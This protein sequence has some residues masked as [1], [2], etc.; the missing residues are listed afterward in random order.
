MVSFVAMLTR[1][2]NIQPTD[3]EVQDQALMLCLVMETLAD[4]KTMVQ[5][6]E[7]L[8]L[9]ADDLQG[10]SPCLGPN[11]L[12]N[13]IA[14]PQFVPSAM[15]TPPIPAVRMFRKKRRP[16]TGQDEEGLGVYSLPWP[17]SQ[18]WNPRYDVPR[19]SIDPGPYRSDSLEDGL[20]KDNKDSAAPKLR[21]QGRTISYGRSRRDLDTRQAGVSKRV[22]MEDDEEEEEEFSNLRHWLETLSE[23]YMNELDNRARWDPRWLNI[24]RRERFEGLQSASVSVI[25]YLADDTVRRSEPLTS[26]GELASALEAQ[27]EESKVRVIMVSDLSRFVMGALG[28]MHSIDPEFWFEHL[29]NSGYGASDSGLKLKNA[30]WMNWVERETRFRHRALPGSGQRTEWNLPRRTRAR[31]WAHMRWGRLGLLHYLGRK[32]F[33]EDE[34]EKRLADGRWTMERDVVLDKNGLLMTHKRQ[35]HVDKQAKKRKKKISQRTKNDG[36]STKFKASN[37]YRA[38]SAFQNLPRNTTWWSNR[39][40]RVMSPEGISYWSTVDEDGKK[41]V[42]IVFDP[43][44]RMRHD[45]TNEET[46]SLTFMPRALEVESYTEDELWRTADVGETYLDPPPP[47]LS[48]KDLRAKKKQA[49]MERHNE[50][51]ERLRRKLGRDKEDPKTEEDEDGYESESSYTSDSEYDEEYQNALRAAYRN[52]HPLV[53]DRDF[54]RKYALSTFDLVYRSIKPIPTS[55]LLRDDSIIPTFLTQ[56][57]LDDVWQLFTEIRLALDQV[58]ADLGA[59]LHVHLVESYGVMTRQNVA[60]MRSTLQE[61]VDCVSTI[62]ALARL[63]SEGPVDEIRTLVEDLTALQRRVDQTLNLIVA[64]T[65]ISQSSLVIDQTSGI[66]KITELAFFFVPLSFITSVFSMQVLE[67]TATP[68]HIWTWGLSIAVV[69]LATYIIRS[70]IRSPSIR[71]IAMHCRVLMLNRFTSSQS[72]SSSRRLNSV[73][74]RAIAKFIFFCLVLFI[75]LV[76][77]ICIYLFILFILYFGVWLG[78]AGTATYFIITRWPDVGVLVAC[79][80]SLLVAAGGMAGVWYWNSEIQETG[81]SWAIGCLVWMTELIPEK[82]RFDKVDDDDLA[83]EGVWTYADQKVVLSST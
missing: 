15:P 8:C 9:N 80:V 65:G 26:K 31:N 40:L 39:D 35:A 12:S 58:D 30:V 81:E 36:T 22:S 52:P 33:H 61:L 73:G 32:G 47:P 42:I 44:R 60:W 79:F 25:D 18:R 63:K 49:R 37:V 34:I 23:L 64:S 70:I 5:V 17:T 38:Y 14:M 48:K 2:C 46:P 4:D 13:V 56:L 75:L 76:A 20:E 45:K 28:Q 27:P 3:L 11:N 62:G 77:V 55:E 66:N 54:A 72:G 41:T 51:R 68:P 82:W 57:S 59:D 50:K 29:V 69:F 7:A 6:V 78:A 19:N 83:Q 43:V 67:L 16:P 71:I 53:R 21:K 24:T 74:N 1:P 10:F